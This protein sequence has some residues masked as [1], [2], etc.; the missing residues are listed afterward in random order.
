MKGLFICIILV[1]VL[2]TGFSQNKFSRYDAYIASTFDL[3]NNQPFAELQLEDTSGEIHNTISLIGKTLYVDFWFTTCPPCIKQI[4][5]SKT[6]HKYFEKDTNVVFLN[7]CIDNI[8]RKQDWKQ[9]IKENGMPGIHLFYA[10]NRP[11]KINLLKAYKIS[12]PTYLLVNKQ[13]KVTGYN[14]PRPSEE[15]LV[16]WVITKATEGLFLSASLNR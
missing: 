9:M 5:F 12:F 11:Q 8:E 16:H 4:P 13:M 3:L 14:A 15:G 10:R 2:V 6:L 1:Q 7:I